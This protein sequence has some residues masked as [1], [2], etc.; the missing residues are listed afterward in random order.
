MKDN[1]TGVT[2]D[3]ESNVKCNA[4][5]KEKGTKT[6]SYCQKCEKFICKPRF[7]KSHMQSVLWHY[8]DFIAH[9]FIISSQKF[10]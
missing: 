7:E 3:W 6:S 5:G 2:P 10:H 9:L 4:T 8:L 1:M